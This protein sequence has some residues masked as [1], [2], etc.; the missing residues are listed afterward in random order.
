MV[1]SHSDILPKTMQHKLLPVLVAATLLTCGLRAQ[2]MN[3]TASSTTPPQAPSA[4]PAAAPVATTPQ[5]AP[6]PNQIIYAPRLPSASELTNVAAAQGLA[7]EQIS[8]T[9]NQVTVIYRDN[10]G[11]TNTVAY[12]LLPTAGT[13]S[14]TTATAV[15]VPS[16]APTV[17]YES[18]PRVVYYESYDPFWPSYPRYY[19]PPVSLSF[20]F[21]YSRGWG[22]GYHHHH[23]R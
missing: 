12:Q 19:Y 6:A 1:R 5:T 18:A 9:A 15:A 13:T 21:G 16:A 10:A 3:S 22:G 20:G 11:Q 7:V 2:D 4:A 23:W 14:G 17:V 8:Q